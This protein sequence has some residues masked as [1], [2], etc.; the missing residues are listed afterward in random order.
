MWLRVYLPLWGWVMYRI[1]QSL[2][3]PLETNV[4]LYVNYAWT[5]KKK[6]KKI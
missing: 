2:Y 1:V 3:Y 6:R 4:T 5:E